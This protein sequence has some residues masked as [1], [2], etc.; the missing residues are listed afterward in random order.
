M[1]FCGQVVEELKRPADSYFIYACKTRK[2]TIIVAASP[3]EAASVLGERYAW[4]YY[5][6]DS[7]LFCE[8]FAL[9]LEDMKGSFMHLIQ[10]LEQT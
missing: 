9:G 1:G 2:Q 7:L 4:H 3:T 10:R 6:I 8:R 5:Q